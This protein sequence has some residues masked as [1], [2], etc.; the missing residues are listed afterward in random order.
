M[1]L[2]SGWSLY[3]SGKTGFDSQGKMIIDSKWKWMKITIRKITE[4]CLGLLKMWN[5]KIRPVP[6]IFGALET[7]PKS[8]G[9]GLAN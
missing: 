6:I 8:V 5:L 9:T 3:P 4:P 7:A 1:T 2:L